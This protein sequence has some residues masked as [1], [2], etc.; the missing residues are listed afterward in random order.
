MAKKEY[1]TFNEA[2]ELLGKSDAEVKAMVADGSL[3]EL[4]DA[5][6]VFFK[7][8]EITRIA[9]KEDSSIVDLA[10]AED[11]SPQV[12]GEGQTDTFASALSS[13]ADESSSLGI[14]DAHTPSPGVEEPS[15]K[16]ASPPLELDADSFPENLPAAP[17]EK[18]PE[19]EIPELSSEIDLLPTGGDSGIGL[20][21]AL[22]ETKAPESA[23]LEVPDLGLSGSSIISLE[24]T[25]L[26]EPAAPPPKPAAK[27][28][29]KTGKVGIS[30]FDDDELKIDVDPMGETR[31]SSGVP[32]MEPVGS[33]SGLLDLTQESDDTSLGAALLDVISP[34]EAAETQDEAVEVIEAAETVSDSGGT[35]TVSESD[36]YPTAPV[37]AAG[38][39]TSFRPMAA[40]AMAGAIPINITLILG[41]ISLAL[42]GLATAAQLQGV[43][44]EFLSPIAK[45]VIHYSV[46]GGLGAIALGTGIWGIL[47]GRK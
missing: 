21:P 9:A 6:K 15:E 41:V 1:C 24:A 34:T 26:D 31:I 42:V 14:L 20:S 29:G 22:P 16:E 3:H 46:F 47:A 32:E 40:A 45:D 27:E 38:A 30:V 8:E 28:P 13:L 7:R 4:R 33:G 17:K 12:S 2:C 36:A 11:M 19:I 44:P 10:A 5:G 43:W 25:G 39:P 23:D 18:E 35:Q 37:A